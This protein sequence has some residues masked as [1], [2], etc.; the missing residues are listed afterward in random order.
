VNPQILDGYWG[1]LGYEDPL[2]GE[3]AQYPHQMASRC[4]KGQS[5][6]CSMA[7]VP[8]AQYM[9]YLPTF[10]YPA[11]KYMHTNVYLVGGF[12]HFLIFH[13]IWDNPSH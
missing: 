3:L 4:T 2:V 5:W 12:K 7:V 9:K 6:Q 13:N 11:A 8:C 1:V 10:L